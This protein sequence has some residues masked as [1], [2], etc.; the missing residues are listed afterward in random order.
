MQNE[1]SRSCKCGM[2]GNHRSLQNLQL[3]VN[4]LYV[5]DEDKYKK[6]SG[7]IRECTVCLLLL[8]FLKR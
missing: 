2:M 5:P 3:L 4:R 1:C 8:I 6:N 7:K